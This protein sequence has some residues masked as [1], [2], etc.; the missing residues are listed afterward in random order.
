MEKQG[1]RRERTVHNNVRNNGLTCLIHH[2]LLQILPPI[3][4]AWSMGFGRLFLGTPRGT[5]IT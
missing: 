2:Q 5:L 4:H 3:R 1:G